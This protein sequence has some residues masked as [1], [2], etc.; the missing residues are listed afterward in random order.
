M[1]IELEVHNVT[2]CVA[3]SG[4]SKSLYLQAGCGSTNAN[5]LLQD[6]FAF[7]DADPPIPY[8]ELVFTA[9]PGYKIRK[10][11]KGWPQLHYKVHIPKILPSCIALYFIL[12][13]HICLK[14]AVHHC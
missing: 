5:Y 7:P 10:P 13:A 4:T 12:F 2:D 14:E 8:T 11:V 6:I 9:V 1:G 3:R